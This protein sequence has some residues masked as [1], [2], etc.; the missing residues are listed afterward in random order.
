MTLVRHP[1]RRGFTL[2]GLLT[3]SGHHRPAR[4]PHHDRRLRVAGGE[5]LLPPE[6]FPGTSWRLPLLCA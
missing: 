3:V 1:A 5:A 6:V 4:V 2:A